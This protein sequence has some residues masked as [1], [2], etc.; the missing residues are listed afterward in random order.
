[1]KEEVDRINLSTITNDDVADGT[2]INTYTK[3][4]LDVAEIADPVLREIAIWNTRLI[5]NIN[6]TDARSKIL[7]QDFSANK[8]LLLDAKVTFRSNR[9]TKYKDDKRHTNNV[10]DPDAVDNA[11]DAKNQKAKKRKTAEDKLLDSGFTIVTM[12][13]PRMTKRGSVCRLPRKRGK[14]F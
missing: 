3:T 4:L 9:E 11:I 7:R 10:T 13:I 8:E 6:E 14:H 5:D 1:L 2:P 12:P